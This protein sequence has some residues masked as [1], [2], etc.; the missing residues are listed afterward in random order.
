[1]NR[2]VST[3]QLLDYSGNSI[4]TLDTP[5]EVKTWKPEYVC[6][7]KTDDVFVVNQGDPKAIYRYAAGRVYMGCVTTELSEPQGIAISHDDQELFV[8]ER[9]GVKIFQRPF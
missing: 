2:I 1:M 8:T 6:C 9:G 3:L 4:Q 5:P 7:S